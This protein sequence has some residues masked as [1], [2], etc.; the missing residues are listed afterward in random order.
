M[1]G[2]ALFFYYL[3]GIGGYAMSFGKA[4]STCFAKFVT[5]SGRASRSEYWKFVLLI[6]ICIVAGVIADLALGTSMTDSKGEFAGGLVFWIV[7]LIFFLPQTSAM[8]RRLHDT[9][10]SGWWYWFQFIPLIGPIVLLVFTCMA[11]TSGENAYGPDPFADTAAVF[12]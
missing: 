10:R 7:V 12:D 6:V 3:A 8:V 1:S 11:G 4:V 5:F 2:A 9:D